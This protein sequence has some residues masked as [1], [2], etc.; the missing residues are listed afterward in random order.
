MP[1]LATSA[2]SPA[3][4]AAAE[5]ARLEPPPAVGWLTLPDGAVIRHACWEPD[6]APRATLLMLNGRSEFIEKY[7]ELARDWNARGFRVLSLDWRGQ[8]LSTRPLPPPRQQRHYLTDFAILEEDLQVFLE[9]VVLPRQAGPLVLYAHS[10][11]GHVAARY[12]TSGWHHFAAAVL[13]APMADISTQGV[14]RPL[15]RALAALMSFA[16]FG[17]AYAFGHGDY[18]PDRQDFAT[19]PVSHDARRWAIHHQWFRA[20][21]ELR[22]GGVTWAW[23]RATFRSVDLLARPET[24]A[25]VDLPMLVLSPVQDPLIPPEAHQ[26]LCRRY[27]KCRLVRYPEARHEIMMETDDLRARAWADIDGFLAG[28][29]PEAPALR[30]GVLGDAAMGA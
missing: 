7:D 26:E 17:T 15:V 4:L 30:G 22:V 16:G 20:H 9:R 18:D 12:L 25:A 5:P 8:G 13:S 27:R 11:G 2:A 1:D 23:L 19:N 29:L 3:D 6:A 14:P 28:V 10:M 21:P 24:S